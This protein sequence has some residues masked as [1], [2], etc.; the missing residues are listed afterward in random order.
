MA[1]NIEIVNKLYDWNSSS[2]ALQNL[3]EYLKQKKYH[4]NEF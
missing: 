2:F 4:L 1:V 3:F